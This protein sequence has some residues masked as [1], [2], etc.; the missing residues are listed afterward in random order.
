MKFKEVFFVLNP[1]L[2]EEL[3]PSETWKVACNEVIDYMESNGFEHKGEL[4]FRSKTPMTKRKAKSIVFKYLSESEWLYPCAEK[5]NIANAGFEF[6]MLPLLNLS[7]EEREEELA[8]LE[9]AF[10]KEQEAYGPDP[11]GDEWTEEELDDDLE[12]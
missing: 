1:F 6:D 12:L 11:D 4:R 8:R 9:S 2:T 5:L 10:E 7:P 3:H